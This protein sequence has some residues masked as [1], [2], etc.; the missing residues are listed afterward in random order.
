VEKVEERS[1]SDIFVETTG[2]ISSLATIFA[3]GQE[4]RDSLI[5]LNMESEKKK[6]KAVWFKGSFDVDE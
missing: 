1:K 6:S 5:I 3:K 2:G 4:N